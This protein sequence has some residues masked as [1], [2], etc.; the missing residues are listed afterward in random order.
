MKKLKLFF[1]LFY[2]VY[3]LQRHRLDNIILSIPLLYPIRFLSYLNP[4]NWSRP[5]REPRGVRLR[6]ALEELGPI[7]VKFGQMLST[8]SDLL[9]DN[10]VVELAKLLDRVPAFPSEIAKAIIEDALGKK[11]SEVFNSFDDTPLASASIAQV[12]A[13]TLADG[14]QVVVKVVRP[15][16]KKI[17]A[18][19]VAILKRIAKL[20]ERFCTIGPQLRPS[21]VVAEFEEIIFYELDFLREAANASQLRRNFPASPLLYIPE[22]YW[23]YAT[24]N[25]MVLERIA[26]IPIAD[27]EQL[28]SHNI[29]LKTLAERGVEIF[30]TQVFRDRFFHAD[31]HAGNIF[32]ST[33]DPENPQYIAVDFGIVGSLDPSDQRY[34]AENMLAFFNRNYYRV[35]ELHVASGWVNPNTK[36][37][38][39]ES[40]IRTIC[41]PVFERPLKDISVGQ[42]L[43]RLFQ[44]ARRFDMTVQPQ[45]V[46]LQKTLLQIEG[47]GRQLY[48]ELDLWNT[49]KPFLEKWL[50]TQIGIR[51]FARKSKQ[52]APFWA[53]KLPDIPDMLY[54]SLQKLNQALTVTKKPPPKKKHY[55]FVAGLSVA[56]V[57]S[58]LGIAIFNEMSADQL[59]LALIG[60]GVLGFIVAIFRG[61]L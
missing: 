34:L 8:R 20:I 9:P 59:S 10:I 61:K 3:V 24:Q 1:R 7:F 32:V 52:A 25:V 49:A 5:S 55:G 50:K 57:I 18:R 51:A 16:V 53:E 42:L 12:H 48:P 23:K 58:G 46:L 31:M 15:N 44:T 28:K 30:F 19:D 39:F 27:I 6:L 17:I 40:A 45:L 13:A 38:K 21:E 14:K 26:G 36:V 29:N 43:I 33:K 60:V 22:I 11:I 35:A 4:F 41:E 37:D 2:I 56:F 54:N 47:L